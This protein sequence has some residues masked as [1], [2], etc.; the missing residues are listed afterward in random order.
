[1]NKNN[2]AHWTS[3]WVFILAATGSAVGL[4]NI[5]KFPYITGENGG[6]AFVLVYLACI[7]ALGIPVMMAEVMLGKAGRADPIK[8]MS[9]LTEQSQASKF[10]VII[11][12]MGV[13]TGLMI[14]SFYSVIAGWALEYVLNSAQGSFSGQSA[15][16]IGEQ[17]SQLLGNNTRLTITHTVFIIITGCVV[18]LGVTKGLGNAVRI[19]MPLLFVLLLLLIAYSLIQGDASRAL[20]FMFD[21]DFSK[22]SSASVL[23]ALGH[24]F[25]TLSLGMGAIMVYGSY[26]PENATIA[27]T[28]LTVA[29]LDTLIA[30]GAGMAIFPLVFA[31]G[32]QAGQ[33]PGL[34][35]VTLPIAFSNMPGGAFFGTVFFI[36][37]A[38]AALSSAIS[39][40]E[41]AV[42]WMERRGI[43]RLRSTC[44]LVVLVWLGGLACIYSNN[45]LE[46]KPADGF[47]F[48]ES[49]DHVAS[50]IMLPLGGI[51]MAVFVGWI[52][53]Q[54][55]VQ[56]A[57]Q[58]KAPA[59]YFC[60]LWA[61]RV[62]APVSVTLIFANTLGWI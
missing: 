43:T 37:V 21:A 7:F 22:L 62:I 27:K 47:Y 39:I 11:G 52:M 54:A 9:K 45:W 49:L 12:I 25:F 3:R 6:G 55:D 26:M 17:F 41:P 31:N 4:G 8:T 13:I 2:Y 18:G 58:I 48:F 10:W 56:K 34:L 5:W 60:W 59:I 30:L 38:I 28:V 51:F 33:G 46:N 42:A 24:A 20:H 14:L 1:M 23:T 57:I 15:E 40:L 53:K 61:L 35:F 32:L 44:S 16:L 36:L 29:V 50:N 19:L